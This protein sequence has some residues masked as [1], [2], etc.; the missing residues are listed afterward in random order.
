MAFEEPQLDV[1]E[2]RGV[3]A[4]TLV[5]SGDDDVVRLEHTLELYRGIPDAELAVVPG[6]SHV[7]ILEKPDLVARLVLGFLTTDP[8]ATRIPI[9]RK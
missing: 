3:Q 8:V 9:R 7:L 1:A 6:T 5:V 2:L 4:R